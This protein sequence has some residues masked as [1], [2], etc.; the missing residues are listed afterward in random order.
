MKT[1]TDFPPADE[2]RIRATAW[3]LGQLSPE[4]QA[5]FEAEM[6]TDPDL[7][8]YAR[9]MR[10]F[11]S[12]L[13]EEFPPADETLPQE[14]RAKVIQALSVAGHK[15][16]PSFLQKHWQTAALL[17]AAACA[18]VAMKPD[19]IGLKPTAKPGP[20][21]VDGAESLP[22]KPTTGIV[23]SPALAEVEPPAEPMIAVRPAMPKPLFVGTPLPK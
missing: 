18:V 15:P 10:E 21:V 11:S 5:A 16:G 6:Q 9:D 1:E 22:F 17:G 23:A 12:L 8:D 7:A 19:L 20:L 13:A 4:D 3:A 2:S 14:T